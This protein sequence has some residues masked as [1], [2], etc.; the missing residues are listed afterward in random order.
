[1]SSLEV[2]RLVRQEV[3]FSWLPVNQGRVSQI[4]CE[5]YVIHGQFY[6][7]K[8]LDLGWMID[9]FGLENFKSSVHTISIKLFDGLAYI[10]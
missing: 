9:I 5:I 6:P 2:G 3:F 7:W 8:I 4:S 10:S 1:M